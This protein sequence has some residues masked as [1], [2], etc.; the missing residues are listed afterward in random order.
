TGTLNH[1][2]PIAAALLYSFEQARDDLRRWTEGLSEEQIWRRTGEVASVGFHIRH[3][4]GSVDRLI[5]YADGR[6]LDE[7]QLNALRSEQND[8]GLSRDQL[9][10]MLDEQLR[11]TEEIVRAIDSGSLVA[12][13]EIGRKRTPVPL[14]VLLVHI[15]EHTQR[16][17]GAAIVTC[18]VVRSLPL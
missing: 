8:G 17:V 14:G 15:S 10:T 4:A 6:Q 18:K 12:I 1:L 16:H 2:S 7:S 11:K 9:L 3:I 13:R 5:T